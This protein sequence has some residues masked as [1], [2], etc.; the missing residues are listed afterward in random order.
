[1]VPY[2]EGKKLIEQMR[3][4]DCH[5]LPVPVAMLRKSSD[6]IIQIYEWQKKKLEGKG[7]LEYD[8]EGHF[9]YLNS[10]AYNEAGLDIEA[11]LTAEELAI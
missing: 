6:Y 11:E 4:L 2:G 5:N 9:Y 3:F 7:L 1:M 10:R 8:K